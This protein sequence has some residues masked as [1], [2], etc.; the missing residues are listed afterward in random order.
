MS[1]QICSQIYIF[2]FFFTDLQN[3]MSIQRHCNYFGTLFQKLKIFLTLIWASTLHSRCFTMSKH[4]CGQLY[5]ITDAG[6]L[7]YSL[8]RLQFI[9]VNS[10][11]YLNH[12]KYEC[13]IYQFRGNC[14]FQHCSDGEV[15]STCQAW[16][17]H[18]PNPNFPCHESPSLDTEN[19]L[20][21]LFVS[22]P[23]HLPIPGFSC[24]L[25]KDTKPAAHYSTKNNCQM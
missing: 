23:Q 22:P 20:S 17:T 9:S 19:V 24:M 5:N 14:S 3:M 15:G 2:F 16:L 18:F 8:I 21:P 10:K 6:E 12:M 4:W 1:C 11:S 7:I 25:W 13:N